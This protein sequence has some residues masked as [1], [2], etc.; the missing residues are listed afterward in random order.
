MRLS[1]RGVR[2]GMG[3]PGVCGQEDRGL[4]AGHPIAVSTSALG[5]SQCF[6]PSRPSLGALEQGARFLQKVSCGQV[7]ARALWR[8]LGAVAGRDLMLILLKALRTEGPSSGA[9]P[10]GA[11]AQ[12]AVTSPEAP[13][14]GPAAGG[15][16]S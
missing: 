4:S 11:G 12:P 13:E 10:G 14:V 5:S 16:L 8:E 7:G 1:R 9:S 6:S 2:K 15:C 3:C